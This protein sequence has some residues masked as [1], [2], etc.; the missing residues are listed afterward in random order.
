MGP[1]WHWWIHHS[2]DVPRPTQLLLAARG[3]GGVPTGGSAL[4]PQPLLGLG[5]PVVANIGFRSGSGTDLSLQHRATLD[6]LD[7]GLRPHWGATTA[8]LRVSA[9]SARGEVAL[10]H[11]STGAKVATVARTSSCPVDSDQL[12][13]QCAPNDRA[14]ADV[15]AGVHRHGQAKR[16]GRPKALLREGVRDLVRRDAAD[17]S[18]FDPTKAGFSWP[19]ALLWGVAAGIGLG[20]ARVVSTRIVTF[21]QQ[22]AT[23]HR[24]PSGIIEE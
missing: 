8:T 20:T 15:E 13:S 9:L 4:A 19:D 11:P 7:P 18:P 1:P 16:G 12:S 23:R 24:P 21:G 14:R 2:N 3:E 10:D 5:W 6:K 22:V 17:P